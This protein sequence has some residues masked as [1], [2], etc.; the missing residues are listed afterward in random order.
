MSRPLLLGLTCVFLGCLPSSEPTAGDLGAPPRSCGNKVCE[1]TLGETCVNCAADCPCCYGTLA[2]GVGVLRP[3]NATGR[4]DGQ[5]AELTAL[6]ALEVT[7][8]RDLVD[9]RQGQPDLELTGEVV[10]ASPSTPVGCPT[11]GPQNLIGSVQVLASSDD[12]WKLV[13]LWTRAGA[14]T[15]DLGCAGVAS[16][17][18]IRLEAQPGAA[19]KVDAVRATSCFEAAQA[20]GDR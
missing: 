16:T 13:G 12:G 10:S 19:A 6:S 2:S 8:G 9:D 3:E 17:S 11:V 4:P 20:A 15:F 14:R 1:P 18:I 5:V 7:L